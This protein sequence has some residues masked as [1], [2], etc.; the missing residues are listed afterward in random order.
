M[1]DL[2]T[3][4][5]VL[6]YPTLTPE[7]AVADMRSRGVRTLLLSTARFDSTDDFFDGAQLGRWLDTAHAAGLKVVG[8]YVPA[9]GDMDRDVRRTVAIDRY[10]SPHGQR[11]D[12]VGIDIE[13]F[14]ESGE[15]DRATFNAS[16]VPHLR[17]VRART[18]AVIAAIVPSPYTTDPGNNWMGFPWSG[19]GPNSEIVVPMTLWSKRQNP[20]G[21]AF[22]P[23]QVH[24]WGVD[25]VDRTQALT[26]RRVHVE[27]G[28]DDPGLETTPVNLRRVQAFV[29]AV[30]DSGAIGG[31]H[32][33]YAATDVGLWL[34]LGASTDS[35][36]RGS[37]CG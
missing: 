4:V 22:T 18:S 10:V 21:T 20:D 12:A 11:F 27:G 14:G 7:A 25:Q 29:D 19:I 5:D 23:E 16:V 30:A 32:Y 24:D 33:D 9:Y 2:G 13:R 26:G 28:V 31:S 6:D 1:R 17:R 35:S 36:A 34:A 8:W 15:V 3:W 37:G